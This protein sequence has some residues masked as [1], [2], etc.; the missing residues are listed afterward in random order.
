MS[1][2]SRERL[3]TVAALAAAV[4]ALVIA[5]RALSAIADFRE[6]ADGLAERM[7]D[8]DRAEQLAGSGLM[9]RRKPLRLA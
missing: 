7:D 1:A 5:R 4:A 2:A 8:R 6:R 9:G 3:A